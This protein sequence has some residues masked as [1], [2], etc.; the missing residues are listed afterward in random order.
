ME[1]NSFLGEIIKGFIDYK[2]AIGLKYYSQLCTLKQFDK[3]CLKKPRNKINLD[4]ELVMEFLELKDNERLTNLTNKATI[5]RGLGKYMRDILDIESVFIV[6]SISSRGQEAYIPYIFSTK[7]I[8]QLL[9]HANT[10][11]SHT[12]NVLPNIRNIISCAFTM[13]YCTGMRLSELINLK[14]SDVN[15]EEG[16]I[17]I[18]HAKNDNKRIVTISY[19][20]KKECFRYLNE[21]TRHNLSNIYFF[22]TGVDLNNGKLNKTILYSYFRCLLKKCD[23]PHLGKGKGPRLHDLRHTFCVHSLT[24][25]NKSSDDINESLMALSTFLG[26]KS[27]YETQKYVWLT[28]ELFKDTLLKNEEYTS[29]ITSVFNE[30]YNNE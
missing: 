4:R 24:Q 5:I 28:K 19:S 29:F 2:K 9:Y 20:L 26:H 10:Y 6:P 22:D 11:S 1:Y 14:L 27:I 30:G 18:N 21:S 17:Y 8:S 13:F 23:I 7:Q 25:L 3:H 12:P 15:L 16:I